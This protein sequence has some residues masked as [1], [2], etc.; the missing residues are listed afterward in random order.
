MKDLWTLG[1]RRDDESTHA[2]W[3]MIQ[4]LWDLLQ[5]PS[6]LRSYP[7]PF[8]PLG[9]VP[10]EILPSMA[11][12]TLHQNDPVPEPQV[13]FTVFGMN[14]MAVAQALTTFFARQGWT[15]MAQRYK[16]SLCAS[17]PHALHE[18]MNYLHAYISFSYRK[19]RPYLSVYLQTLETGD[20]AVMR[21][22]ANLESSCDESQD[23]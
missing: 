19:G 6:G 2:G 16:E 10:D 7:E 1:G 22:A 17:Y 23:A 4:E 5:I 20:W 8:L 9:A 14:D 12:Y 21:C 11:N 15:R 3:E 13:Y 18:Q